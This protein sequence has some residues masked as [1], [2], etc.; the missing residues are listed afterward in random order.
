[1]QSRSRSLLLTIAGL[2]VL[3]VASPARADLFLDILVGGSSVVGQIQDNASP[4]DTNASVGVITVDVAALNA[5]LAATTPNLVFDSLSASS[6]QASGVP[7]SNT[8][9]V[10]TQTGAIQNTAL[11]GAAANVTILATDHDYNFPLNPRV[12]NS[13][14]SATFTDV[15]ASNQTNFQSFFNPNNAHFAMVLPSSALTQVPTPGMNPSS[16]SKTAPSTLLGPQ[17]LP[18]SLTN[19]TILTVGPASSANN[20]AKIGFSGS[21][22]VVP[23]PAA[24]ALLGLGLPVLGLVR[25]RRRDD[26]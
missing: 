23:E 4:F 5:A 16:D 9:A 24:I 8:P 17:S 22:R 25:R 1:M 13:S 20:P 3:A 26:V 21:T 10:L 11:S 18:F 12:L 2:A 15:A 19:R 6:N 14:A 7:F